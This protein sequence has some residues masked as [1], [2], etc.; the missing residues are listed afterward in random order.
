MQRKGYRLKLK[1]AVT[2]FCAAGA[3]VAILSCGSSST[4]G[5]GSG[6]STF[7]PATVPLVKLS[8]DAFTNSTSPHA[9]EV[10]PGSFAF[11]WTIIASFQVARISAGGGADIGEALSTDA[12]ISWASGLLP[13]ITTFQGAGANSA[14]SD[15]NVAYDAK[16]GVWLISS[17]PISSTNTQVAV[18]R[19]TD[20]GATWSNP[21]L[22]TQGA[23]LDKTWIACDTTATSPFY[24]NCYMQWDDNNAADQVYMRTSADGGWTWSARIAV[25]NVLGLGS[26]PLV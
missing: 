2:C 25:S 4:S 24:G 11:G 9:T 3:M 12:G 13:G 5:G 23:N 10:E 18:N 16:R 7:P 14:V 6:G 26:N 22:V 21:V 20:G 19:S 8:T 1:S 17:L 15:T